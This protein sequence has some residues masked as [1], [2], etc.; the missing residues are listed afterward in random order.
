MKKE[1]NTILKQIKNKNIFF[2]LK[3]IFEIFYGYPLLLISFITP[4]NKNKICIGSHTPFNDNSKYFY[5]LNNITKKRI[6]WIASTKSLVKK[7][8]SYNIASNREV[9]YKWSLKGIYHCLTSKYY[10]FCFHLIDIN[11][12][13]SGN[14]IKVNLWHG[15]PL[16]HIEFSVKTG[17]SV[18]IYNEKNIISRI[19][20]PYIFHRPNYLISTS[21]LISKYYENAFRVNKNVIRSYGQPR[22]D[23]FFW[24]NEKLTYFIEKFEP[25]IKKIIDKLKGYDQVY[26]YMPTWRDYDFI[27]NAKIDFNKLNITLKNKKAFLLI[28]TH[29]ATPI[30][31]EH[32][33]SLSNILILDNNID[34]YPLLPFTTTLITDYSSIYYD[35]ILLNK[36]IILFCFDEKEYIT[37]DRGFIWDYT[38]AMKGIRCYTF[39]DLI[40]V[41]E[42]S[43]INSKKLP[44]NFI[45]KFWGEYDGKSTK[46]IE[47]LFDIEI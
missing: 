13:T 33:G 38:D 22:C 14:T 35:Y 8:E 45:Q 1:I 40:L 5:L 17:S 37:N 42:Q 28:K 9:Y 32:I 6:I 19:F 7:I 21:P 36:N 20:A 30:N 11:Y 18:N 25:K 34:V 27:K 44:D 12:W 10:V 47:N 2:I 26:I 41:I 16:K 24:N 23:I 43:N 46:H 15:I 39:D 3:K 31:R 29:P 4:R